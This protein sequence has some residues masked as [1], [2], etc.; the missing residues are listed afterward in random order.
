MNNFIGAWRSFCAKFK[1]ISAEDL[2]SK[3]QCRTKCCS[4]CRVQITLFNKNKRLIFVQ[5]LRTS[6]FQDSRRI[7]FQVFSTISKMH[8]ASRLFMYKSSPQLREHNKNF[9][10][11]I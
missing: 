7:K 10:Q 1:N 3:I 11:L 8:F 2:V 4:W 6:Q 5:N 9:M